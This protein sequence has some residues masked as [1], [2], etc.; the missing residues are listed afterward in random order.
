MYFFLVEYNIY[1]CTAKY[2][3]LI[4]I[5]RLSWL[6]LLFTA[7]AVQFPRLVQPREV[8]VFNSKIDRTETTKKLLLDIVL[9]SFI[10]LWFSIMSMNVNDQILHLKTY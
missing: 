10:S 7:I 9:Q 1:I 3:N 4:S 2:N 8:F 6:R 5:K